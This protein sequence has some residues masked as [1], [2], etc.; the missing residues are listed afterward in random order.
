MSSLGRALDAL[1]SQ[2]NNEG[3]SIN[4]SEVASK[5]VVEPENLSDM[6]LVY[7]IYAEE[8]DKLV[9]SP[10]SGFAYFDESTDTLVVVSADIKKVMHVSGEKTMTVDAM[11]FAQE[12]GANFMIFGNQ[13]VCNMRG[14]SQAGRTYAEAAMRAILAFIRQE[15]VEQAST[16][17]KL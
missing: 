15:K 5:D 16:P 14:I 9:G 17:R 12:L 13:V 4:Q 6:H 3:R 1:L 7:A 2:G 8:N 11:E 10:T